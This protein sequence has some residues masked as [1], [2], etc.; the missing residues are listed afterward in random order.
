MYL[1]VE[2]VSK[3]CDEK[4]WKNNKT[5]STPAFLHFNGDKNPM[6]RMDPYNGAEATRYLNKMIAFE[7]G[8]TATYDEICWKY[9][10]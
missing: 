7:D 3:S 10:L 1:A 8:R 6:P 4:T 5:G 2:D 9:N